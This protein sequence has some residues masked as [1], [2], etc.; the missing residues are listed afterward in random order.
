MLHLETVEPGTL[1]LIRQL[2]EDIPSSFLV[3]FRFYI[4]PQP[5]LAYGF[6]ITDLRQY[7][8]AKKHR[9]WSEKYV[10]ELK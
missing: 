5:M 2:Q 7:C 3:S 9:K 6:I 1:E 4:K 10:K 8:H